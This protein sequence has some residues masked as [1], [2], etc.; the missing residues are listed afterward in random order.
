M[1]SLPL[2]QE[3]MQRAP[4]LQTGSIQQALH[5]LQRH[6]GV[7]YLPRHLVAPAIKNGELHMV[8]GA[9]LLTRPLYLAYRSGSEQEERIGQ[10]L[11]HPFKLG[12]RSA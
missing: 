11:D 12:S 4:S 6:G 1:A 8:E 9:P 7:A 10:L 2:P 3:L 5:H